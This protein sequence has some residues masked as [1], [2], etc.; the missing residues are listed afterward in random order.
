MATDFTHIIDMAGQAPPPEDGILS[1]TVFEDEKIKVV[2]FGFGA[3]QE[4]TEHTASV[5]AVMHFLQGRATLTLGNQSA[6]AESGT[7]IHMQPH[8]QHSVRAEEPTV[9]LLMLLK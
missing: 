2:M 6:Q 3:G 1:R 7:W 9:M 4:L 8:L 5:G